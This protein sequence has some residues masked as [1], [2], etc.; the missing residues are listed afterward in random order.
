MKKMANVKVRVTRKHINKGAQGECSLCPVAL[1]LIDAGFQKVSVGAGDI[2]VAA[3]RGKLVQVI[4]YD[5]N[6]NFIDNAPDVR[7]TVESFVEAF[8]TYG[9][10]AVKPF[11]FT[12]PVPVS[13][14]KRVKFA[15]DYTLA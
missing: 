7:D 13:T 9:P 15:G 1:A 4:G 8:D 12:L 2:D 10:V 11:S 14:L 6:N 3:S 5:L